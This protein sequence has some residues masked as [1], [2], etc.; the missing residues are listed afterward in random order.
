MKPIRQDDEFGCAIA[1]IAFLLK[2]KYQY[3]LSLF[4]SGDKRAKEVANFYCPELVNILN[5]SGLKYK[6]E[7]LSKNNRNKI[8]KHKSMVFIQKNKKYPYGHFL[9]RYNKSWMDPWINLPCKSIKAGFRKRLPGKPTY[10]VFEA[11]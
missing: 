8:Y 7:K 3:G 4:R 10:I 1:C 2:I 5:N 6:Y 9:T 11:N